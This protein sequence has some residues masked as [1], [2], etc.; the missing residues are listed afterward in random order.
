MCLRKECLQKL[1]KK[2]ILI[3]F[4]FLLLLAHVNT[5]PLFKA[6]P[7]RGSKKAHKKKKEYY[8][9]NFW[10]ENVIKMNDF[11]TQRPEVKMLIITVISYFY[12][13]FKNLYHNLLNKCL[14]KKGKTIHEI[15]LKKKKLIWKWIFFL[16]GQYFKLTYW[17]RW[18]LPEPL[19]ILLGKKKM[20]HCANANKNIHYT[21]I[22]IT[23][24][25]CVNTIRMK[26]V[27][28]RNR[29]NILSKLN[30]SQTNTTIAQCMLFSFFL[31]SI[32]MYICGKWYVLIF[33]LYAYLCSK[34]QGV[35]K[36]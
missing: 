21:Y 34:V 8:Q 25:N 5:T 35:P 2:K 13:S 18:I 31:I 29:S 24:L 7:I 6:F 9:P 10:S 19:I 3:L 27:H 20:E 36:K 4:T 17:T 33:F 23:Q 32:C 11:L 16:L 12:Y 15:F 14:K 28:A 22:Y 1:S 26:N 30:F